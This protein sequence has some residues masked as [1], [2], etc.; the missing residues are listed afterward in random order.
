MTLTRIHHVQITIPKS[1][2][3]QA[4]AFYCGLLGLTEIEKPDSLKGRGGLWLQLG[5]VQI[6]LGV[7]DGVDRLASKAHVAYE[8]RQSA[9]WLR[10]LQA[11]GITIGDS[12]PIPGYERF[13][14]R[15]PFGNR[16]EFIQPTPFDV[17]SSPGN[18]L[19]P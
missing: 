8:V 18:V 3:M 5:E 13:E 7:E 2:E 15:D 9:A 10:K 6:H 16:V 11:N 14:F 12:V 19:P 1:A 17:D 4:R